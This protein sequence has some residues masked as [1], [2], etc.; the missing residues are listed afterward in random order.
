MVVCLQGQGL[1]CSVNTQCMWL[2]LQAGLWE[3]GESASL[4]RA[5]QI[6]ARLA[7]LLK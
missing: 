1:V 2:S 5:E 3:L 4:A 6:E 7:F